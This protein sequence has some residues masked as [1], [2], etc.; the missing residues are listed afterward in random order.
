MPAVNLVIDSQNLIECIS[1]KALLNATWQFLAATFNESMESL[2]IN[3]AL[4]CNKSINFT[5][6]KI[7]RSYNYIGKS[8][9][10]SHGFSWSF[11]DD[12]RFY[13]KSLTK[14]EISELM[15]QNET[16]SNHF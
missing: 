13:N 15:N 7:T 12:L 1:N 16:T 9:Y 14:E 11:M 5:M 2:Y 4:V 10:S 6:P 8:F 3:G